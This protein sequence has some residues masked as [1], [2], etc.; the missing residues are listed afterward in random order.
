MRHGRPG[1]GLAF[2]I[3]GVLLIY[4]RE[5]SLGVLGLWFIFSLTPSY[6]FHSGFEDLKWRLALSSL[7]FFF[8]TVL[9]DQPLG[10][11]LSAVCSLIP[12]KYNPIYFASRRAVEENIVETKEVGDK[13]DE[14]APLVS[15]PAFASSWRPSFFLI[16]DGYTVGATLLERI[17]W[18]L[19]NMGFKVLVIDQY[20]RFKRLVGAPS[21]SDM[22]KVIPVASIDLL[23][24]EGMDVRD[25]SAIAASM[26]LSIDR[27]LPSGPLSN[28]I[29]VAV[30]EA[31]GLK[32][33]SLATSDL[34][35]GYEDVKSV[36]EG[37]AVKQAEYEV[38]R[39]EEYINAPAC[40]IIDVSMFRDATVKEA[41]TLLTLLQV[42][43]LC[44][45]GE[46]D[47]ITISTLL[48]SLGAQGFRIQPTLKGV[49]KDVLSEIS[50]RG[51]ILGYGPSLDV[52]FLGAVSMIL[53]SRTAG[54]EANI[55][56]IKVLSNI[57]KN[58]PSKIKRLEPDVA[59]KIDW[60]SK[61]VESEVVIP[62]PVELEALPYIK[63]RRVEEVE[64]IVKRL[65]ATSNYERY[66]KALGIVNRVGRIA[67]GKAARLLGGE[68]P[69]RIF[70]TLCELGL[71]DWEPEI[72]YRKKGFETVVYYF[73]TKK[74]LKVIE[75]L[76]MS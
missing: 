15:F 14:K 17:V 59:M 46:Y 64:D 44:I 58:L 12:L 72:K 56:L 20:G 33:S 22:V 49:L 28:S 39:L 11:V 5:Y 50:E 61:T 4:S 70:N 26:L 36:L 71:I 42:Y 27:N 53:I 63:K 29:R 10:L 52:E 35:V 48:W 41:A 34:I 47:R 32:I 65:K 37:I 24:Y 66:I 21:I 19:V 31:P 68:K 75:S 38:N 7:V 1:L 55:P 57:S 74:G 30:N 43:R 25:F 67:S 23:E 54:L 76:G 45:L 40:L 16:S 9:F 51:L 3:L 6:I 13:K 73:M 8:L 2:A 60:T 18:Y 69:L 62:P